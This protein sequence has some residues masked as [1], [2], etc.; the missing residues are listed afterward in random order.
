MLFFPRLLKRK[1]RNQGKVR[2]IPS[3]FAQRRKKKRAIGLERWLSPSARGKKKS[4]RWATSCPAPAEKEREKRWE[5]RER[6][7]EDHYPLYPGKKKGKRGFLDTLSSVVGR[8]RKRKA[9]PGSFSARKKKRRKS[10]K[11]G[12][13]NEVTAR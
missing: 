4:E 9:G 7:E 12:K 13:T 6:K 3:T 11:K 2:D 5:G 1:K 8:K 10:Q